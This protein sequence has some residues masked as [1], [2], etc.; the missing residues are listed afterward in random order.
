MEDNTIIVTLGYKLAKVFASFRSDFW[1][2]LD[3]EGPLVCFN[4]KCLLHKW[5]L[6]YCIYCV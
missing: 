1:F 5:Q 4:N 3:L 2:K 6:L